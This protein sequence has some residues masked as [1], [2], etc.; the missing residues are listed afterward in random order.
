[1]SNIFLYLFEQTNMTR[2]NR[3]LHVCSN[4]D[5][6]K[7]IT[8]Y[9]FIS[10]LYFADDRDFPRNCSRRKDCR[11]YANSRGKSFL[12]RKTPTEG[13]KTVLA[14][15]EISLVVSLSEYSETFFNRQ[16][17]NLSMDLG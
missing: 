11:D 1:M 3:K 17:A 6:R 10:D 13:L 16:P 8:R 12:N 15:I 2:H 5:G 9:R 7:V 14:T 4:L